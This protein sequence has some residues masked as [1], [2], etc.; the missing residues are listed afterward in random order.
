MSTAFRARSRGSLFPIEKLID[1][2]ELLRPLRRLG[3]VCGLVDLD[4]RSIGSSSRSHELCAVASAESGISC[5]HCIRRHLETAPESDE[6][7]VFEC[8]AGV[9][10]SLAPIRVKGEV[11]GFI[12]GPQAFLAPTADDKR[13]AVEALCRGRRGP[14]VE[15]LEAA[16]H[17]IPILSE[18]EFQSAARDLQHAAGLVAQQYWFAVQMQT[19]N[20][21]TSGLANA[22]NP[23]DVSTIALD[24][25]DELFGEVSAGIYVPKDD[26]RLHAI[27]LR[28]EDPAVALGEHELGAGHVG[29]VA[30]HLKPL[31]VRDLSTWGAEEPEFLWA[32]PAHPPRSALT[33]PVPGPQETAALVIQLSSTEINAFDSS[34][35][36]PLSVIGTAI[37]LAL[38]RITRTRPSSRRLSREMIDLINIPV[39]S[40]AK[41]SE[42]RQTLFETLARSALRIARAVRSSVRTYDQTNRELRFSALAGQ[43]WTSE[44]KKLVYRMDE[45]S[46][47]AYTVQTRRPFFI[48]DAKDLRFVLWNKANADLHGLSKEQVMGKNDHD[49]FDKA[50][51]DFFVAKDREVLAGGKLLD[52]PCEEVKTKHKGIRKLHT[53]KIPILDADGKPAFLLGISEDIT[54]RQ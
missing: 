9:H 42:V 14:E 49:F 13:S 4:G 36:E 22:S 50:E 25:L 29:W 30:L 44:I 26:G 3:M 35:I 16:L 40:G 23:E 2:D 5:Q 6:P 8:E 24:G 7:I 31:L 52:I 41:L 48:K 28:R 46:A 20:R 39:G 12:R 11:V 34:D 54:D 1:P 32:D 38:D 21:A 17:H 27:G 33:V 18:L 10:E 45:Q 19:L 51:A 53:Q 47:A 15:G 37:R 43:G